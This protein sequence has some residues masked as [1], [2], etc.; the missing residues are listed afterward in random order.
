[1]ATKA[2]KVTVDMAGF[3][4]TETFMS[5]TDAQ[6]WQEMVETTL[7]SRDKVTFDLTVYAAG[8]ADTVRAH[9]GPYTHDKWL[10]IEVPIE[11]WSR[12]LPVK[13]DDQT[14]TRDGSPVE[15]STHRTDT[16]LSD[17]SP[18][19]GVAAH[20]SSPRESVGTR[21]GFTASR[22]PRH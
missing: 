5:E 21:V 11:R 18:S 6:A 7:K 4:S 16:G 14:M 2:I 20:R 13:L 1:M 10:N 15:S 19:Q 22:G 17:G 3:R 8:L 9:G 12:G